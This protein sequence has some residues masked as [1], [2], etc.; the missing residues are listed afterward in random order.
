MPGVERCVRIT[1]LLIAAQLLGACGGHDEGGGASEW[2]CM[3][4][5]GC[6]F[7]GTRCTRTAADGMEY[8]EVS[9]YPGDRLEAFGRRDG[10]GR[11]G[12]WIFM[13]RTGMRCEG[14]YLHDRW[15][16]EWGC[17]YRSGAFRSTGSFWHG[18]PLGRFQYYAEDGHVIASGICAGTM[19]CLWQ[20]DDRH[21]GLRR[22]ENAA[23]VR[24]RLIESLPAADRTCFG[25]AGQSLE[26]W[27]G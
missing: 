14:D 1:P 12:V 16:G 22:E 23:A 3:D 8:E 11:E 25:D 19:A 5:Q 21:G 4:M 13:G 17:Q 20:V 6:Q 10:D 27:P 2:Q 15:E 7:M 26:P 9:R 18:L 24:Q